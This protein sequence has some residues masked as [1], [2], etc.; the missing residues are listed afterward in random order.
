MVIYY[1]QKSGLL[2]KHLDLYSQAFLS[3]YFNIIKSKVDVK[4]AMID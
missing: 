4:W 1:Y 3:F 2:Y